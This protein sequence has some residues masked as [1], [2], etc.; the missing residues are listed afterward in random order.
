MSGTT[1]PPSQYAN[2][3]QLSVEAPD[4]SKPGAKFSMNIAVLK[5]TGSAAKGDEPSE[6]LSFVTGLQL[7][8]GS[9]GIVIP[10]ELLYE[11]G[12]YRV[13]PEGQGVVG[14]LL[15]GVTQGAPA[16]V[17][18]QPSG[19]DIV[20]FVYTIEALAIGAVK[21]DK[22][23]TICS[24]VTIIGAVN[25][26]SFMCGIG[27]GRPVLASN[28]FL[29]V[30]GMETNQLYPSYL[31]TEKG[32]WL[33]CTPANVA[34]QTAGGGSFSFQ[35]LNYEGSAVSTPSNS[36]QWSTPKG[37]LT[38]TPPQPGGGGS[39]PTPL[40]VDNIP[41]LLDTGLNLMMVKTPL[42]N[43]SDYLV[44]NATVAISV[45]AD[46]GGTALSYQFAITGSEVI[47]GP[48][49]SKITVYTTNQ[50]TDP[51]APNY[52]QPKGPGSFLNTGIRVLRGDQLYF[53]ALVG[54]VGY[55]SNT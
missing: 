46:G 40:K 39:E 31:M 42:G 22:P 17:V 35:K 16:K 4:W 38:I 51:M 54:Q 36:S 3:I 9:T 5:P 47:D 7:D 1:A 34:Q 43:Q 45:A 29:S 44:D 26:P 49:N 41:V 12:T 21:G 48:N 52:V 20:G 25:R 53:D 18:Y 23:R 6:V 10:A 11:Q 50:S 24:N 2:P 27:F 55:A 14:T 19:D 37:L 32:V 28:V 33:G 15:A 13:L 30:N 8:T